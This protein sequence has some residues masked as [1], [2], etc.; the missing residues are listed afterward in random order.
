M[1][2]RFD[3]WQHHRAELNGS[4]SWDTEWMEGQRESVEG[5]ESRRESEKKRQKTSRRG[6]VERSLLSIGRRK[7]GERMMQDRRAAPVSKVFT[8]LAKNKVQKAKVQRA[9]SLGVTGNKKQNHRPRIPQPSMG[10]RH[11]QGEERTLF[12]TA[13]EGS[14]SGPSSSH[15]WLRRLTL[16]SATYGNCLSR[17]LSL[18]HDLFFCRTSAPIT[19]EYDGSFFARKRLPS[20]SVTRHPTGIAILSFSLL[21]PPLSALPVRY[22]RETPEGNHGVSLTIWC[23]LFYSGTGAWKLL[24]T[25]SSKLELGWSG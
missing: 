19:G 21:S 20:S 22:G 5:G 6:T 9:P 4:N 7:R 16:A 1:I 3:R 11:S 15:L 17:S 24:E 2:D 25:P 10:V 8:I 23:P 12:E 13:L 18:S 14:F